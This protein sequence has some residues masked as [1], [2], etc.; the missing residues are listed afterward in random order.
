MKT[1]PGGDEMMMKL[2]VVLAIIV[3]AAGPA[4]AARCPTLVEEINRT[5]GTR[6][7]AAAADARAKAAEVT[8][9]HAAGKH[10]ESEKLALETLEKLG[11]KK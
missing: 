8:A 11:I 7:D 3:L 1:H 5:V 10:A 9:L 6:F 2:L 4:F